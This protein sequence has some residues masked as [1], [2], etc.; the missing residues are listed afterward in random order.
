[1]SSASPTTTSI[2]A[3]LLYWTRLKPEA[4]N[5][6]EQQQDYRFERVLPVP[7]ESLHVVRAAL[8]DG[9][10]L[11]VGIEAERLR[12]HL[13][14]R[15]DIT[16]D[17]W[18]LLPDRI[19]EHIAGAD[20]AGVLAE[21]NLL[22]GPFEPARRRQVRRL[23]DLAIG[24]GLALTLALALAGIERRVAAQDA[25]TDALRR[26]GQERIAQV[27]GRTSPGRMPN[28]AL[29]TQE[30]RRL[31][32]AARSTATAPLD[33]AGLLQQL[34][35]A[36]PADVRCQVETVSLA[37]DRLVVRGTVPT[38]VDA[39]RIAKAGPTLA[40]GDATFLAAPLQAEQTANGAVFLIT[41]S[42]Q[43]AGQKGGAR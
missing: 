22:Q 11:L 7:V 5:L 21:L 9:G 28:A 18:A 41:W 37:P 14:Q 8:A 38:L 42:M 17:T 35:A 34:W 2:D 16:G 36:W 1:M 30:L 33:A 23:R 12:A 40:S 25:A 31:E 27:L 39:E 29:L 10:A 13:A 6:D 4:G 43:A 15:Q 24:L 26:K 19:P 3:A 20:A 32:Q